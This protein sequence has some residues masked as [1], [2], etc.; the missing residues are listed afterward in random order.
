MPEPGLRSDRLPPGSTIGVLGGGQL[1]R[2]LSMAAAK[3]GLRTHVYCDEPECPAF[4][5]CA[6]RTVGGYTDLDRLTAFAAT[7]DAVTYE[8]ENVPVDAA[9]HLSAQVPVRPGALA[10][11]IAQD[12]LA[13]K[14]FIS[15]LGVPVAPFAQVDNAGDLAAALQQFASP[16]ILKTRRFGYDG[17]G[18]VSLVPGDDPAA[19]LAEISFAPAILEQRLSFT[20]E[21]SVLVVRG[22]DGA[23]DFYDLPQNTHAGGILRRSVVPSP[24]GPAGLEQARAMARR[25]AEALDYAG[26]L[27]VEMFFMGPHGEPPLLVNEIAPRVHN[28]GHWT[29]DAC[30]VSQFENHIRAVAG[31][32]LGPTV[33]H[34]DAEMV[35]LIGEDARGWPE[36]A[37]DPGALL[38]LYGKRQP[39]NGRKMGHVN[40]LRPRS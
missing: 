2:M 8:F 39:R 35:N 6:E 32:P 34:S 38:H 11:E 1:G 37:A 15:A 9:R 26:V 19:A 13:E 22:A 27:A 21:V 16:G 25:I 40:R 30:G 14:R 5:V 10:L 7:V 20:C 31:W 36:L 28:S 18:Q 3:L 17:K 4:D 24:L 12:R 33:R 29:M 23:M